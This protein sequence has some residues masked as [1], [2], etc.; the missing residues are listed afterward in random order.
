MTRKSK[1]LRLKA[2][3]TAVEEA[4]VPLSPIQS[5]SKI[6]L[7]VT[8]ELEKAIKQCQETVKRIARDCRAKN[9]KYRDI[10]FDFDNDRDLCLKGLVW[11]GELGPITASRVTDIYTKPHFFIDGA[12]S[13]D[14][15]QGGLGD[16]WF[17]SA[18]ATASCSNKLIERCCVASD[19]KVGVYGFVFFKHG[20]WVPIIIDDLLFVHVPKFEELSKPE[21]L[22]FHNDKKLYNKVAKK[23]GMNLY[24]ARSGTENE[25]WVPLIEK[26]YAKLHGDYASLDGGQS[27]EALEDMT[28]GVSS[29][30]VVKDI[31][32]IDRF[33]EEELLR[34]SADRLFSAR[35]GELDTTRSGEDSIE[36]EGLV[37]G[38]AYSVLKAIEVAGKRFLVIRN[39][40]GHSEWTGPWSDGSREWTPEWLARLPVIGHHFANDGQF[41]MEYHDFLERFDSIDRTLLFDSSWK[42]SIEWIRVPVRPPPAA[43]SFGA[44]SFNFS[45]SAPAKTVIVLSKLDDRYFKGLEGQYE[46]NLQFLV[47]Q[48]TDKSTALVAESEQATWWD[49]SINTEA[50]LQAGDYVVHVRLDGASKGHVP[51]RRSFDQRKLGRVMTQLSL[52]RSLASTYDPT[53]DEAYFPVPIDDLVGREKAIAAARLKVMAATSPASTPIVGD[54]PED[55]AK[56]SNDQVRKPTEA[57]GNGDLSDEGKYDKKE[58]AKGKDKKKQEEKAKKGKQDEAEREEIDRKSRVSSKNPGSCGSSGSDTDNNSGDEDSDSDKDSNYSPSNFGVPE[59]GYGRGTAGVDNGVSQPPSPEDVV[60]GLSVYTQGGEQVSIVGTTKE[61]ADKLY[62]ASLVEEHTK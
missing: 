24:F 22:L 45:L 28:G 25:T 3:K 27:A 51:N 61:E 58:R 17:L 56:A 23:G 29:R 52:A 26:A 4:T 44:V 38:H 2:L 57:T 41:L 9:R 7:L 10:E 12:G 42:M 32:D 62:A 13:N 46:W 11:D 50:H 47:Y 60:I 48:I 33:W 31:L 5:K 34:A 53:K 39:P 6:G 37:G 20:S 54:V 21:Q 1:E 15:V 8:D 30:L 49:R 19:E 14:I 40:W 35:F 18:L 36:V 16:C 55:L 43:W 59:E